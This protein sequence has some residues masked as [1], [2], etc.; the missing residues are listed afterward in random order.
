MKYK[1][2]EK[3]GNYKTA[4]E[5]YTEYTLLND[6]LNNRMNKKTIESLQYNYKVQQKEAE[7]EKQ[8]AKVAM[9]EIRHQKE[10]F[11]KWLI[12]ATSFLIILFIATFL[13]NRYLRKLR[14]KQQIF[15]KMLIENIE[16]ERKRIAMDLHDDIGQNL[17]VIKSKVI[18]SGVNANKELESDIS[19]LIEQT[20]EISRNL[21]PSNIEKIG[22]IRAV[23]SLM[24]SLQI[25]KNL[26]CSYEICN[27][28]L[29]L[30]FKIQ[31]NLFRIIQ[32][33]INNTV[34]HS[35]ATGLKITIN[36]KNGE[37][38]MIY[39]DNGIGIKTK[40]SSNGIGLMSI[41][42]RARIINGN[43]EIDDKTE[44]GFRL[45]LK[46]KFTK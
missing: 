23:A 42:E 10:Q 4:L 2:E 16:E 18:Q 13:Y 27:E 44:R 17:S 22:L 3:K 35:G 41:Q 30:P 32:E 19:N 1:I 6:S 38:V 29:E 11:F 9:L 14:E 26:E 31:T 33:C 46:F 40:K 12:A 37:F 45:I 21:Y 25:V 43:I 24:E 20:R 7:L 5:S 28:V 15:S 39:L 36:E 34:K 8:K